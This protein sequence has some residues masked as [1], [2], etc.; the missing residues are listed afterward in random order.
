MF[1]ERIFEIP[2]NINEYS[3]LFNDSTKKHTIHFI[4]IY[5]LTRFLPFT[6]RHRYG[7]E[8]DGV[9]RLKWRRLIPFSPLHHLPALHLSLHPL[10]AGESRA[11]DRRPLSGGER[12]EDGAAEIEAWRDRNNRLIPSLEKNKQL[13]D[14]GM[15]RFMLNYGGRVSVRTS[16]LFLEKLFTKK[17]FIL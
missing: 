4:S 16:H 8:W 11:K 15:K 6:A 1:L 12:S 5:S 2:R 7:E 10:R 17:R 14:R 3:I 13:N 9:K